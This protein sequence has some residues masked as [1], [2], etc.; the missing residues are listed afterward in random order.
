MRGMS[1]VFLVLI[2]ALARG[3]KVFS[4]EGNIKLPKSEKPSF[5]RVVL[6]G[7][8]YTGLVRHN[9]NFV[10]HDLPRGNYVLDV[11]YTGYMFSQLSVSLSPESAGAEVKAS[12]VGR[13]DR[14]AYP[15]SIRPVR[16]L[17]YFQ[18]RPP[19][20]YM[21]YLKNPMVI[22]MIFTGVMAIIMPRMMSNM[23]PEELKEIQKM[24]NPLSS[25]QNMLKEAKKNAESTVVKSQQSQ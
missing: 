17:Q 9:G 6:N 19:I 22:M 20:Q 2:L 21:S 13:N 14:L 4:I 23:D 12:T 18:V 7:G 5:A 3:A 25:I 11:H 16:Q 15:L 10:I 1:G 24:Q 8:E